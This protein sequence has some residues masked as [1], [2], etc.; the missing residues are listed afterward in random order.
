MHLQVV[1]SL[2]KMT[3]ICCWVYAVFPLMADLWSAPSNEWLLP[4][5]FLS[6]LTDWKKG[7]LKKRHICMAFRGRMPEDAGMTVASPGTAVA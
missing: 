6:S 7:T 1:L 3:D 4:F 5:G 2:E